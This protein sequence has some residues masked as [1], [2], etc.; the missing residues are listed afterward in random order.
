MCEYLGGRWLGTML[1]L[2]IYESIYQNC[3]HF[4]PFGIF[5]VILEQL[6]V[7]KMCSTIKNDNR[8]LKCTD[9]M[10][11]NVNMEVI[12]YYLILGPI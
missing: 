11:N 1:T 9:E 4:R 3:V 2:K 6:Y 7:H 5:V 10:C 8:F 12:E